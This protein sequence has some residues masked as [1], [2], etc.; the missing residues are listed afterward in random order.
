ME[1]VIIIRTSSFNSDNL[2]IFICLVFYITPLDPSSLPIALVANV[3]Y[4]CFASSASPQFVDSSPWHGEGLCLEFPLRFLFASTCVCPRGR[5]GLGCGQLPE[6]FFCE[7]ALGR[8]ALA[9]LARWHCRQTAS[10]R[11]PRPSLDRGTGEDGRTNETT[12]N[13]R[14]GTNV[15]ADDEDDEERLAAVLLEQTAKL[16][17]VS[18]SFESSVL[19][20]AH[21]LVAS[22]LAF[23]PGL[24]LAVHRRLWLPALAYLYTAVF[25]SVR[26]IYVFYFYF[27]FSLVSSFY[28]RAGETSLLSVMMTQ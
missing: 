21:L 16:T 2:D 26:R 3:D 19:V 4:V 28:C 10:L 6:A 22:N 9:A 25:S 18:A 11:G 24:L 5:A 13:R 17:A 1:G 14:S 23:L 15:A 20:D 8:G 12:V 27:Y 7:A